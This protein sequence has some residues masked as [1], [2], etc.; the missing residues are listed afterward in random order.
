[1][2]VGLCVKNIETK[3]FISTLFAGSIVSKLHA[4]ENTCETNETVTYAVPR[5]VNI[6]NKLNEILRYILAS[7]PTDDD[8]L[9]TAQRN[10]EEE[11]NV[12]HENI[13]TLISSE[14]LELA[15]NSILSGEEGK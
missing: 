7:L 2:S 13:S 1:M 3:Y 14:E 9:E 5:L 15:V 8:P 10:L 11:D 12:S 4:I 6:E